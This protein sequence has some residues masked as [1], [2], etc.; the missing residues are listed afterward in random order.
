MT[1]SNALHQPSIFELARTGNCQ[2]LSYWINSFLA[3]QG[4][5]VHISPTR[6]RSLQVLIDFQKPRRKEQCVGLRERVVRFICYRLWMLNSES[7]DDVRIIG[8]FS[9]DLSILWHQTVRI[10]TPANSERLRGLSRAAVAN[11]AK[12]RA[13]RSVFLSGSAVTG[14]VLGYWTFYYTLSSIWTAPSVATE[15]GVSGLEQAATLDHL[16]TGN[17]A[18]DG[19]LRSQFTRATALLAPTQEPPALSTIPDAFKGQIIRKVELASTEKVIALTFDDGPWPDSTVQMLD[20]LRRYD[21]KATFFMVGLHLQE[22]PDLA[23]R[24]AADGH[25]IGNHSMNHRIDVVDAA[26][27]AKEVNDQAQLIYDVTGVKTMLFRPP[28]GF[29]DTGFSSYAQTQGYTVLMWSVDSQDYYGSVPLLIDNVLTNAQPGG[30]VL[31][32]DGGGDRSATLQALPQIITALKQQGY[33]FV[34]VPELLAMKAKET[35][36]AQ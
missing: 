35:E 2:A 27:A 16:P 7:I 32:H 25:A 21:V 11:S 22:H 19:P 17:G 3:P 18:A 8:R 9:K 24:V 33:R 10:V 13:M 6:S 4:M 29:L 14:F 30:I 36:A 15:A 5:Y 34:T 23:K 31:M 12:F 28:G 1:F 20:I 26:T